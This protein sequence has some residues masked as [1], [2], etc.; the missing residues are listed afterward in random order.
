MVIRSFA[1]VPDDQVIMHCFLK[2]GYL[3]SF[4][5]IYLAVRKNWRVLGKAEIEVSSDFDIDSPFPV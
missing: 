4:L 1:R 5:S 3:P 2:T